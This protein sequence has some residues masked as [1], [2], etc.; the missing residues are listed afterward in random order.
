MNNEEVKEQIKSAKSKILAGYVITYRLLGLYKELAEECMEELLLR[1]ENGDN[2]NFEEYIEDELK[3][4]P[5]SNIT[6][7]L[8]IKNVLKDI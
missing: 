3:N 2:F 1:R 6:D 8:K 4:S 7:L 5:K